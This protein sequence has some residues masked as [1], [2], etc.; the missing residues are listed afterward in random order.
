MSG[1]PET[2]PTPSS[3]Q[4]S[5]DELFR[6]LIIVRDLLDKLKIPYVL[7]GGTFLGAFR[8]G[9]IIANDIDWDLE[10]LGQDAAKILANKRA[11]ANKGIYFEMGRGTVKN[12]DRTL[13]PL[14]DCERQ[15]LRFTNAN[16]Q[17][18]GDIYVMTLFSD[19]MLRRVNIAKKA[20][21]NAKMTYPFWYFESATELKIRGKPFRAMGEPLKM[22]ERIYGPRWNIPTQRHEVVDAPGYNMAGA[23][24]DC[25]IETS[26]VHALE[27]GWVPDNPKAP[28]WPVDIE[29]TDAVS[30]IWIKRHEYI[31]TYTWLVRD[32]KHKDAK[33][34][35]AKMR[36][37]TL[38]ALASQSA[39]LDRQQIEN[40]RLLKE[41]KSRQT[42]FKKET[43]R[44]AND[45]RKKI[46]E[47]RQVVSS[48]QKKIASL[49]VK[50]NSLAPYKPQSKVLKYLFRKTRKL[51]SKIVKIPR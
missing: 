45:Y 43:S 14:E 49:T 22:I 42:E 20:Y 21:L 38:C 12:L 26:I 28:I 16:G 1:N 36:Q 48:L 24:V 17:Q 7:S 41:L 25:D 9:N 46:S 37:V 11:F 3:E 47:Q 50:N 35:H 27:N 51:E 13:P 18:L 40:H 19:G 31:L 30:R 5:T 15:V 6:T 23:V 32:L 34:H 8:E 33:E 10:I 44:L 2:T 39:E 4:V 29:Y